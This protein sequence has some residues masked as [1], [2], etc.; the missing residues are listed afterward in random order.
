MFQRF[1]CV[2]FFFSVCVTV[3]IFIDIIRIS[4][5]QIFH[6]IIDSF[7]SK[8]LIFKIQFESILMAFCVCVFSFS[9]GDIHRCECVAIF[10]F[11]FVFWQFDRGIFRT[12]FL[13]QTKKKHY[14]LDTGMQIREELVFVAFLSIYV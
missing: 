11:Y 5:N 4:V 3:I 13:K 6:Y 1:D 7:Q 2:C 14:A 9:E 10:Y 12:G 8:F